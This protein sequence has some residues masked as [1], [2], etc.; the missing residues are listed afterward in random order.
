MSSPDSPKAWWEGLQLIDLKLID[1][2]LDGSVSS[3][4]FSSSELLKVPGFP[5]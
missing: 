3:S 4:L 2:D 1:F 5:C